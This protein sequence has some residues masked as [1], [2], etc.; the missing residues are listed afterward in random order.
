VW[1]PYGRA[2]LTGQVLHSVYRNECIFAVP[3]REFGV[4]Y[5]DRMGGIAIALF[6]ALFAFGGTYFGWED[7]DSKVRLAM[8]ACFVLGALGAYRA[9]S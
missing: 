8:A 6:V 3:G 9:R 1:Q 7:P 5:E 4:T 2:S